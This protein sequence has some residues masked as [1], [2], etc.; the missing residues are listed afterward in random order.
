MVQ[1]SFFNS[2]L[3]GSVGR[4]QKNR[5]EAGPENFVYMVEVLEGF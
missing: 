2:L 3:V 4:Q 5:A 1:K